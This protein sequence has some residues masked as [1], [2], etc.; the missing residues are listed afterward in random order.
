MR[1]ERSGSCELARPF[2]EVDVKGK[3]PNWGTY[4]KLV[5]AMAHFVGQIDALTEISDVLSFVRDACI[6]QGVVR[7]SYHVTPIFAEP[8]SVCTAVY[9]YGFSKEWLSLYETS[10]FRSSDPI[11]GRVMRHGAPMRWKDAMK[12]GENTWENLEYFAAM[13]DH[14][15][16]HGF[17]MPLFGPR[18]RDAYA[19]FD[20]GKP[21]DEVPGE[22]VSTVRSLSQAGHQRVSWLI[23]QSDQVPRLSERELEVLSWVAKGKSTTS[24]AS[25]L[26]L[27]PDTVKTYAKRIYSK[28]DA[29]DRVGAV[30][31]ALRLGL[32]SV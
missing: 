25:I 20:F 7:M 5:P 10:D 28:L 11:P 8:N 13:A 15:L 30:V 1:P 12:A 16:D 18:G 6:E 17:G 22:R 14:G 9:A 23:D 29:S 24:I 4:G 2:A 3:S 32:V 27:S 26:A 21:L 31:K 19:G